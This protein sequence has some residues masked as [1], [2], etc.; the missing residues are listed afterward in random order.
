MFL[1]ADNYMINKHIHYWWKEIKEL[2]KQI[3]NDIDNI[4]KENLI[5]LN[6]NKVDRRITRYE[7][8]EDSKIIDNLLNI[9][10]KYTDRNWYYKEDNEEEW[11]KYLIKNLTEGYDHIQ[12]YINILENKNF[13]I[14]DSVLV[15]ETVDK[16]IYKTPYKTES[17]KKEIYEQ[18][19]RSYNKYYLYCAQDS[20]FQTISILIPVDLFPKERHDQWNKIKSH[21]KDNEI[22]NLVVINY[23]ED[24]EDDEGGHVIDNND[25]EIYQLCNQFKSIA[26]ND[27]DNEYEKGRYYMNNDDID[28][29]EYSYKNLCGGFNHVKNYNNLLDKFKN[30][31]IDSI[32]VL[33]SRNG[34][35]ENSI[36]PMFDTVEE[37]LLKILSKNINY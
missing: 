37:M 36:N 22:K 7:L 9:F 32:L 18:K 8:D 23:V 25:I 33:E 28:W 35:L 14:I 13:N 26:D 30:K 31:I 4:K 21:I 17:E 15:L 2:T 11:I 10:M 20:N 34:L 16:E 6:R 29:Q 1:Y 19:R 12:N 5:I 27:N 24:V 3:H